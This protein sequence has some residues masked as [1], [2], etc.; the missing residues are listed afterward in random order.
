[1]SSIKS[2]GDA[3]KLSEDKL[4]ENLYHHKKSLLQKISSRFSFETSHAIKIGIELEFYL[5]NRDGSQ[6]FSP[7]ITENFIADL[8]AKLPANSLI[9]KIEKEQG[10][11]Q[12]EVKTIFDS[13]LLKVCSEIELIKNLAKNLAEQ[14]NLCASF[15][16]QQFLDDCGSALQFNISLH[17]D[18]DENIFSSD[19]KYLQKVAESLLQMT[20]E[21]L[22]FL[23]PEPEDYN[24]FS[25]ATNL[26]LFKKGK[27]TAPI[28]LSFGADNRTCAIRIPQKS[29]RLEYRVAA[30]GADPALCI[31]VIL[32]AIL[33][34]N[35][36]EVA[37]QKQIHGNAFDEQ[38]SLQ[39]FC[40][41]L[42]EAREKFFAEGGLIRKSL[43][44]SL[45]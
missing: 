35:K 2:S 30:A 34:G 41:N 31:S 16:A 10:V 23:A 7:Q 9:Y 29:A 42:E 24:R 39:K 22:I 8:T 21:M 1:M 43:S 4:L 11:G 12:I 26:N 37:L 3:I 25:F 44:E 32:L 18:A 5:T 33:R 6:I 15:L 38:Y 19:K 17:N 40:Q 28:N 27:F 20:D 13:D 14:K 45:S 36:N